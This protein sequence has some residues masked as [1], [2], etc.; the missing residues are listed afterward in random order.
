MSQKNDQ[1]EGSNEDYDTLVNQIYKEIMGLP[2]PGIGVPAATMTAYNALLLPFNSSWLIAKSKTNS[3]KTQ[4][5]TFL[6][7][8]SKLT[9]FLRPFVLMWL[10][11]NDNCSDDVI[12]AT[13]MRLHSDSRISRKGAPT[14]IPVMGLT[15]EKG[16]SINVNIRTAT[17]G[18]GKPTGVHC[19]RIRYFVGATPPADPAEF[20]KFAD[21]TANP[22]ILIL[23][24][25]IAG[26]EITIAACYVSESGAVE[27]RYCS[28]ISI[29]VP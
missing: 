28:E 9:A 26:Q 10:Y 14:E 6:T 15:P 5:T 1:F 7:N 19:T 21:F 11:D 23:P 25:A 27:G 3:T 13:G 29:N 12:T 18:I 22:M 20:S 24:A 17:G 16:H 8:R 2:T 4:Q